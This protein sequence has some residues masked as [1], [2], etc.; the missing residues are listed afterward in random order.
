ML[1]IHSGVLSKD[2]GLYSER[3]TGSTSTTASTDGIIFHM[4]VI[5]LF[6]TLIHFFFEILLPTLKC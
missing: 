3:T 5:F 4:K 6:V 2:I 1:A